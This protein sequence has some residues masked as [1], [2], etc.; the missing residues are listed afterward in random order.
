MK[1]NKTS[2]EQDL[3]QEIK[4]DLKRFNI[5]FTTFFGILVLYNEIQQST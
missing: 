5:L 4:N 2:G 3:T 1:K